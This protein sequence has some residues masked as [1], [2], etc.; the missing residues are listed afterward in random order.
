[1]T[2]EHGRDIA[3]L[4][5]RVN[6]LLRVGKVVAV[7]YALARAR[8]KIGEITTDWLPWLTPSTMAWIPLKNG[9]Q[10][11][12][13]SPSG[14]LS[15]GMILPALYQTAAPAPSSDT[16]KIKI[17]SDIEQTG[18]KSITGMLQTTGDIK[19]KANLKADKDITATGEVEGKG[20]KLSEH[21]HP[22]NY[23]GAGQASSP[24]SGATDKP[25]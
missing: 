15:F 14:D 16:E 17:I 24:Q 11:V 22:F 13:L 6:N 5:R 2:L 10:V 7:D 8:V 25:S 21:T 20:V 23:V 4:F 1:M 12:V 9:E 19:T 3:E 18:D